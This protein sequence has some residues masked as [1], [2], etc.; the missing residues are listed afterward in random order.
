MRYAL[1]VTENVL[2]HR[3]SFGKIIARASG[4]A[5]NMHPQGRVGVQTEEI[6]F[7]FVV[8]IFVTTKCHNHFKSAFL[9]IHVCNL[10]EL[11][12]VRH[13]SRLVEDIFL[14]MSVIKLFTYLSK[15]TLLT[16]KV[17]IFLIAAQQ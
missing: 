9:F 13:S 4:V 14:F 10:P 1:A 12:A 5:N 8:K 15:M 2:L 17:T 6:L 11:H 7:Y 3:K 16:F